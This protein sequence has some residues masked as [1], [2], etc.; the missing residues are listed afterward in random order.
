MRSTLLYRLAFTFAALTAA[1]LG[2]FFLVGIGDGSVSAFNIELW[3]FLLAGM[4]AILAI[5]HA[6]RARGR[7]GAAIAVLAIA[8]VPGLAYGLFVLLLIVMQPSWH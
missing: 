6:L 3:L 5:G 4:A 7:S 1:L 2:V 8:A